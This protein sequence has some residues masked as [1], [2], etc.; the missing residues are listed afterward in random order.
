MSAAMEAFEERVRLAGIRHARQGHFQRL[1]FVHEMSA[2]EFFN[3]VYPCLT[4]TEAAERA[5][6]Y[7]RWYRGLDDIAKINRVDRANHMRLQRVVARYFRRFG[8]RRWCQPAKRE[9]V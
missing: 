9:E 4:T 3:F 5:K 2:R 6:S 8:K 1:T 7:M